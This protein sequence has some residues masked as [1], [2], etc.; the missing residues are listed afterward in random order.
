MMGN[1]RVHDDIPSWE[2]LVSRL[3]LLVSL[4]ATLIWPIF[5][6]TLI[7]AIGYRQWVHRMQNVRNNA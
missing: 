5:I 3:F 1:M 4:V 6:V 7:P 2:V